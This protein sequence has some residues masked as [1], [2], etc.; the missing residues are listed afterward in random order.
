VD[1]EGALGDT[2]TWFVDDAIP[3]GTAAA[4]ALIEH[5]W[6]IGLREAIR[7]AGGFHLA[8]AWIHPADLVSVGLLAREEAGVH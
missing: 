6:A 5:R 1:K 7:E 8:D 2:D 3:N 4:I